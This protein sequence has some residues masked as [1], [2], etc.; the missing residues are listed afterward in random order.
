[1][2][3]FYVLPGEA[4]LGLQPFRGV[5][6]F[7]GLG[8]PKRSAPGSVKHN[9]NGIPAC[10]CG[11]MHKTHAPQKTRSEPLC[12]GG[13]GFPVICTPLPSSGLL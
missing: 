5:S 1:V 10:A 11:V 12:G 7:W 6:L 3:L 8:L 2:I 9:H 4:P 13:S